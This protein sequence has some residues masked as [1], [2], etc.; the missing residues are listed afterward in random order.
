MKFGITSFFRFFAKDDA[1]FGV[2]AYFAQLSG[3]EIA[4][5]LISPHK[6]FN[7]LKLIRKSEDPFR[8]HT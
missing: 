7:E 4:K 8:L 6:V 5:S 2:D 1:I 3:A